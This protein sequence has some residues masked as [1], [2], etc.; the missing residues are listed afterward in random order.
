MLNRCFLP[1]DIASLQKTNTIWLPEDSTPEKMSQ[2]FAVQ[3]PQAGAMITGWGTPPIT[4]AMLDQAPELKVIVHSAG[5]IKGLLPESIWERGIRVGTCNGALAVGVAE[6]TLGMIIAGLKG[7]FPA[8]EWTSAG[9]WSDPK[10]GTNRT[11][12]R[13]PFEMTVGVIGASKVGRHLLRLLKNFE[14]KIL[15]TDPFIDAGQARDLGATLVDLDEVAAKSDVITLHAPALP[16]T[17]HMLQARHFKSMKDGAI[18][19]NTAR[20]MIVDESALV[21]EL[22]TGRISAFIDVTDSE[23]PAKDHPFRSLPNVVLTPH[24]A[25]HASNGSFRQ[26]RSVIKQLME[27]QNGEQMHGEVT[28]EM[29]PSMA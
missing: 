10:L 6:T 7:F 11:I 4:D 8:R 26:G 16:S 29:C 24:L 27:Y 19:I 14:M 18:F 28:K 3:A 25:G 9:H 2:Q 23:P 22:K 21:A 15:L 13:E 1:D 17:H 12:I 5:S 20:G